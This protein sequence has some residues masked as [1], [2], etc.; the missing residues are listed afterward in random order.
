M[1]IRKLGADD[2]PAYR[3][4]RLR[5]LR[6]HPDAFTSSFEEESMRPLADSE[7]RLTNQAVTAMWAAFMDGPGT[8]AST[9]TETAATAGHPV[10]AGMVGLTRETRGKNRHKATL[11]AMY[12][13]PE[14]GRMGLGRALVDAVVQEAAATGIELLVLTVTAGNQAASALYERAGFETFGIEPDAVRINGISY[15]KKHMYLQMPAAASAA[16]F[17]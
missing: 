16:N 2:A 15:E 10:M 17:S 3:E 8:V 1:Q 12:V 4:F 6:E 13:A 7:K 9:D 11:V 14:Y 5:A